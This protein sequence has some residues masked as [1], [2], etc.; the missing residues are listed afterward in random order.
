[1][2]PA[3][4]RAR[5]LRVESIGQ[6][7]AAFSPVSGETLLLNDEAA[8]VLEILAEGPAELSAVC[9]ALAH[10]SDV[11]VAEVEASLSQSWEHFVRAGLVRR[12]ESCSPTS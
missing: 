7:W 11:P 10:D 9:T 6:S 2:T 8:A 3:Y 1:M 12:M 5:G 4:E